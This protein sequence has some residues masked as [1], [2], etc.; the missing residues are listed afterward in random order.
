MH[1]EHIYIYINSAVIMLE[2]G[3]SCFLSCTAEDK[4]LLVCVSYSE[5][6]I[7]VLATL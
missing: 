6:C 4:Q 3:V 5:K 2:C 1:T 7:N